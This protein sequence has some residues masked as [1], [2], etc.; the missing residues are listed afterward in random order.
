MFRSGIS[1]AIASATRRVGALAG[2]GGLVI[3]GATSA[4][5]GARAFAAPL[6]CIT[7]NTGLVQHQIVKVVVKGPGEH[8]SI[9]V[10]E[11]NS[12]RDDGRPTRV[13]PEPVDAEQGRAG[14]CS[15]RPTRTAGRSCT[16]R[17]WWSATKA[18]GDGLC[19]PRR[20]LPL[21]PHRGQRVVD[22][23]GRKPVCGSQPR[24]RNV[25]ASRAL[26]LPHSQRKRAGWSSTRPFRVTDDR[27]AP[28]SLAAQRC[29]SPHQLYQRRAVR[30]SD[31]FRTARLAG[32]DMTDNV[33]PDDRRLKKDPAD[34][35]EN[36]ERKD[37]T[38]PTE[39]A[40]PTLP[41]DSTDPFESIERIEFS[42][43]IDHRE[44]VGGL[45][46]AD[47]NLASTLIVRVT[48]RP[49]DRTA[50]E[51]L[52]RPAGVTQRLGRRGRAPPDGRPPRSSHRAALR[53]AGRRAGR[54]GC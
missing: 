1:R 17:C 48:R 27:A 4:H 44:D 33:E 13:Q 24:S 2:V 3:A 20:R 39:R 22:D 25:I 9:A 26:R 5:A 31:L 35:M 11:C 7:P 47:P 45:T 15:Q 12:N 43:A 54:E 16:T 34:P 6:V 21:L 29:G 14:R 32:C 23:A 37:P 8:R 28:G 41:I 38:D 49:G 40:E 53:R 10:T 46:G 51:V 52:G 19:T 30:V 36:A 42:E 50:G 18:V